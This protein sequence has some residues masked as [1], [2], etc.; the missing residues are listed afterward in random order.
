MLYS[1]PLIR[2][3][4]EVWPSRKAPP[5]VVDPVMVATSGARLLKPSAIR[6]LTRDLFPLATLITPNLDEAVL[7]LGHPIRSL[8]ELQCAAV[9]LHLR[10]GCAV[11]L[12]GGHL[13]RS[14]RASD[15]FVDSRQQAI[16]SAPFVRGV[17]THGTGCTYSAAITAYLALGLGLDEAVGMGKRHITAAIAQSVRIGRHSALNPFWS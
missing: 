11:L 17:S 7:L 13:R 10:F 1:E 4:V 16:L 15:V 5:L 12:K 9:E 2:A 6:T 8:D 3:L 14:P